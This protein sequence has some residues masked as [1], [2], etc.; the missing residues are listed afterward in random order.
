[1]TE[2]KTR[3]ALKT[4]K[5]RLCYHWVKHPFCLGVI[6]QLKELVTLLSE[7]E[8]LE[9]NTIIQVIWNLKTI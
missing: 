4:T 7:N 3:K 9:N 8:I 6:G 2:D 1:M 5:M